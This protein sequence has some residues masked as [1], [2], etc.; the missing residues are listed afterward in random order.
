[1]AAFPLEFGVFGYPSSAE[2]QCLFARAERPHQHA[3]TGTEAVLR[4]ETIE[5]YF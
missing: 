4:N 1:M 2:V 3:A 5:D